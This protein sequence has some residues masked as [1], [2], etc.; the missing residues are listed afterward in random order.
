MRHSPR[1]HA[2]PFAEAPETGVGSRN[3]SALRRPRVGGKFLFAG[4]EKL[5]LRGVTY[6]TFRSREDGNDYPDPATVEAD[7]RQMTEIGVNSVRTYSVP[8]RYLLDIAARHGLRVLVG[9]P[10]EQHVAFLGEPKL[11]GSIEQRVREGVRA[12]AGHP[13]LLAYAVGNEIP[14]PIV[15]WHGRRRVEGFLRRLYEA[16]KDEDP[17]GLVTYVNFPTTE[18]LQLPFLDFHCFN[19]YLE[20]DCQLEGYLARLQ[21]VT[22]DHPLVMAEIGLDSRRNGEERQAETVERQLRLAF[23]A[24]CAGTFVF[25]WTDEWHRGGYDV[26]DWDFGLTDRRRRPKAALAAVGRAFRE[27]P[28][29]PDARWPRVSVVVCARNGA[30]TLRWCLEGVR[31]LDYPDYEAIVVDDG[32]TDGTA[33]IASECGYPAISIPSRGLSSARNTGLEAASGEIVA[34]IDCDARPDC[35]WLRYLAAA[36]R[37]TDHAGIGGPNLPPPDGWIADCVANA[38]GGPVHVLLS[39]REAEHIPGCNMAFRRQRLLEVGGFDPRFRAA[40]DDVDICWRLQ[41]NGETLGFRAGAVVWHRA[42][43]SVRGYWRQQLGYGRAEA[44]L[45]RKWPWKYNAGGHYSWG[46]HLYGN[47]VPQ[48]VLRR[49]RV[50]YGRWGTGLFQAMY[51]AERPTLSSL[52]LMPEWYL[53]IALLAALVGLGL[54][55]SPL[56]AVL[57]LAA[58]AGGLLVAQA[59]GGARRASRRKPARRHRRLR[60]FL[61]TAFLHML[62]PFARLVGRLRSGLTPW[63]ARGPSYYAVPRPSSWT[64]WSQRWRSLESWVRLI[65]K[66]LRESGT[67][68]MRGGDF[69]R[70]DLELR[71][72]LFGR[73]RILTAVEEHG[74]GCQLVRFRIWPRPTWG[75]LLSSAFLATLATAA[76]F[77]GAPHA[78]AALGLVLVLVLGVTAGNCAHAAGS[79]RRVAEW[80]GDAVLRGD[81][82]AGETA[83]ADALPIGVRRLRSLPKVRRA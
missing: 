9:L 56:L 72:G 70:W 55:W 39:D 37:T 50:Y 38:P 53:V 34:Y 60:S 44:L 62:Q 8:P 77:G 76:A 64:L 6:G 36:F 23:A 29:S 46:G 12:C 13:A 66:T 59:V 14:A 51:R 21:N 20:S 49:W 65:E 58:A 26:E 48:G 73:A 27:V 32:S 81:R 63:R 33:A 18:Y 78:A 17:G 7:F 5:Y 57:P 4:E 83:T 45:E 2:R 52:A 22:G 40:G 1:L 19:V 11:A 3:G 69:D 61:M 67:V 25:A 16:A 68:M 24:G 75:A 28:F 79:A 42:R 47:G 30:G 15:R 41:R 35:D 43:N 54:L 71:G 31:E 10:W 80:L 82:A 74:H